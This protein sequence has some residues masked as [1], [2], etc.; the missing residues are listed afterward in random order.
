MNQELEELLSRP[1]DPVPLSDRMPPKH[2]HRN[3]RP[4]RS[5]C[6]ALRSFVADQEAARGKA[7]VN[8][9]VMS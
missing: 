7:S 6:S 1:V 4:P 2:A 3:P 9:Q 5:A 8:Q